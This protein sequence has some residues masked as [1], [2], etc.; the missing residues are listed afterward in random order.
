MTVLENVISMFN[1]ILCC[2]RNN[3]G[4]IY[5]PET[6]KEDLATVQLQL[7]EREETIKFLKNELKSQRRSACEKL[8]SQMKKHTAELQTQKSKYQTVIKRHQKFI[9]QIISEKKDLTEKCNALTEH[10]KQMEVKCQRELKVMADRHAVELQRARELC[11]ASEKIRRER[12]LE[13]RTSKIKVF[14]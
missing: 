6:I 7:E 10:I 9:E 11:A 1:F 4:R 2:N 13:A 5:I 14:F 8:D 3:P 12:W